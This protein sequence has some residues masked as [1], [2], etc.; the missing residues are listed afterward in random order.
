VAR[1]GDKTKSLQCGTKRQRFDGRVFD[2][3][4]AVD[5]QG[6]RG[7]R[8]VGHEGNQNFDLEFSCF[9]LH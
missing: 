9:S 4:N 8:A 1:D 7:S 3:F 2:V 6:I 5:A